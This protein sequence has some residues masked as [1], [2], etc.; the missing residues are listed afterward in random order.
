MNDDNEAESNFL[1]NQSLDQEA[2]DQKFDVTDFYAD[3]V[4]QQLKI[5][6][7]VLINEEIPEGKESK[8][9][10]VRNIQYHLSDYNVEVK[11]GFSSNCN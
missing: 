6:M 8:S 4:R 10:I 3:L 2:I 1:D 9:G 5:G 11:K 7:H